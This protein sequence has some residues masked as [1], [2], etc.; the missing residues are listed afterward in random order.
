MEVVSVKPVLFDADST[1][2]DNNGIGVLY[3][4][5]SCT[6][7]EEYNGVFDLELEY[8]VFGDWFKEI[9]EKRI[10]L[11]KPNDVDEPHA[12]RI[13]EID[14]SLEN[15]NI[16]ARATSV[17]DDLSGNLVKHV[18]VEDSTSQQALTAIKQNLMEPTR[19]D[20]ISDIQ[21]RSASEWTR[22]NPLRAIAGASGSLVDIWGGDIKRTND[23]VYLYSRRGRDHVTVIRP[24]KNIEGFEMTVSLKG[25]ITKILPFFTYQVDPL[26]EYEFV[27]DYDGNKVKQQK[28]DDGINEQPEPITLYGDVVVSKNANLYPV[29]YY[30]PVDYSSHEEILQQVDAYIQA[31]KDADAA[32][33][34]IPD[35]SGWDAELRDYIL[36]LVNDSAQGYFIYNNPNAD[37]PNVQIQANMVELSDSSDWEKFKNLEQIQVSDTV[38]VYVKKFGVDVEVTIQAIT[39]DSI[40]ERVV[41][42][43]AGSARN[44]LTDSLAKTYQDA[45]KQLEEYI[46]TVENGVYNSIN[47]TANGQSRKFQGYTEP[48][49]SISKKGD[50]WFKEVGG[51]EVESYIFDGGV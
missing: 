12:F 23:A 18:A 40:G 36:G 37:E 22:V 4:A 1:N 9:Q 19:F 48:P 45:T 13:Y 14:K 26:P 39:Y 46:N 10:I 43:T 2:F 51:G 30:S 42:I 24:E 35:N 27:D 7:T 31:K 49:A 32:S 11:A 34:T 20:L 3:D 38:D 21:T 17:T 28:Y 16:V 15:G 8:P 25:I 29:Q 47:R 41:H 50:L 44:N 5:E 6:V 33:P